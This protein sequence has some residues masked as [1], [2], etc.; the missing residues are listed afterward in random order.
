MRVVERF[1]AW[2]AGWRAQPVSSEVAHHARRA[3]ID[4]HAALLEQPNRPSDQFSLKSITSES[5]RRLYLLENTKKFVSCFGPFL[6]RNRNS[7]DAETKSRNGLFC[8]SRANLC[9]ADD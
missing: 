2:A 6:A 7:H 5:S 4:W 9:S 1:A 3:V 8:F